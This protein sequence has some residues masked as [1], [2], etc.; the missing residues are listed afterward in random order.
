MAL[1]EALAWEQSHYPGY[2]PDYDER[3]AAFRKK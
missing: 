1:R 3:V 2:A